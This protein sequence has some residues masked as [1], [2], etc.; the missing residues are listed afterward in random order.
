MQCTENVR[1]V[2]SSQVILFLFLES[3]P[4]YRG[5]VEDIKD[6][7]QDWKED[8]ERKVCDGVVVLLP[9]G[10]SEFPHLHFEEDASVLHQGGEHKDNAGNE[11]SL[12][13]SETIRLQS[14][15]IR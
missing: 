10:P 8:K 12:D 11:P 13:S 7:E 9:L 2:H 1:S 6:C 3:F 5:P 4:A 15:Y 14:R